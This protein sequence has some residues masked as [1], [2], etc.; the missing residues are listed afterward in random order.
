MPE[1]VVIYD[2]ESPDCI[3]R[4]RIVPNTVVKLRR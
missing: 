1:P 2:C 4:S 3:L